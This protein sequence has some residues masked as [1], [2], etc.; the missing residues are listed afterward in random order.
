M[1]LDDLIRVADPARRARLEDADSLRATATYRRIVSP[2]PPARRPG[3]SGTRRGITPG[4]RSPISRGDSRGE[5]FPRLTAR[6]GFRGPGRGRAT[7]IISRRSS[8]A[9]AGTAVIVAA[10]L[11]GIGLA[12][13]FQQPRARLTVGGAALELP[14]SSASL[15]PSASQRPTPSHL[16]PGHAGLPIRLNQAGGVLDALAA[17]AAGGPAMLQHA[18]HGKYLYVLDIELKGAPPGGGTSMA[19]GSVIRQEWLARDG[20]GR[21]VGLEPGC[22]TQ[23]G[24]TQSWSRI[25]NNINV[26]YFAWRGL[27]TKPARLEAAIVKRFEGGTANDAMTFLI[28]TSILNIAAPPSMRSA[29][30]R[31]LAR[32]PN[33]QY[34]GKV[35]DPLGRTGDTIGLVREPD[36]LVAMFDPKTGQVL[37]GLLVPYGTDL[38][39]TLP[40]WAAPTMYVKTAVVGSIK[41]TPPGVKKLLREIPYRQWT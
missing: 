2:G 6:G 29:V 3:A 12:G 25:G 32:L 10:G 31:M 33:V 21:Q 37:D 15:Q 36:D 9:A 38:S 22:S 16:P 20:S 13:G 17:V 11:S 18:G 23:K 27:P 40:S 41:A 1:Q 28:A 39:G 30:F 14:Q 19:C 4:G 26:N 35:T 34:L 5:R 24:F 8:L 7:R